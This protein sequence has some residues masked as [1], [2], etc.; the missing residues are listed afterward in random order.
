MEPP[1][2]PVVVAAPPKVIVEPKPAVI[3]LPIIRHVAVGQRVSFAIDAAGRRLR[4]G[5]QVDGSK[6]QRIQFDA[7]VFV[8]D[9]QRYTVGV[10][11][12]LSVAANGPTTVAVKAAPAPALA[13]ASGAA[14]ASPV[15][16]SPATATAAAPA[17]V[18]A[19]SGAK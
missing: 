17:A 13:S 6:V 1:A 12:M 10:T 16:A 3:A 8:R 19:A 18:T 9:G 11:P 2:A 15:A 14:P 5:D 4:V 7:V